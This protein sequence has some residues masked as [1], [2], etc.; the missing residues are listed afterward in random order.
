MGL[1]ELDLWA[2]QKCNRLWFNY[3]GCEHS[4]RARFLTLYGIPEPSYAE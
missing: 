4:Q 1:P 2:F 3:Y